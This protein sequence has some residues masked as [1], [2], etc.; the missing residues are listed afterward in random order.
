MDNN[1]QISE[2][3]A[4]GIYAESINDL[5]MRIYQH[6][7]LEDAGFYTSLYLDD[8]TNAE[9]VNF[10]MSTTGF[11]SLQNFE[12]LASHLTSTD[13]DNIVSGTFNL[14]SL[15]KQEI[16]LLTEDINVKST[17]KNNT[18][19]TTL[20]KIQ[21][22]S[23]SII[24]RYGN[25][26]LVLKTPEVEYFSQSKT[27]VSTKDI[28]HL[29]RNLSAHSL[30]YKNASK[31]I[32][33]T[34]DGYLSIPRM[35]LRGY[36]ELFV[37]QNPEF[38]SNQAKEILLRE[39][40]KTNNYLDNM[41]EV[42]KALSLIKN[43]FSSETL[44]NYFRVNNFV[45]YR[46]EYEP[47]FFTKSFDDK[48][49]FLVQILE[50]N[51]NYI[52]SS[53]ETINPRI[54]YNLQQLVSHELSQR[55][56]KSQLN[57]DD[58]EI[59]EEVLRIEKKFDELYRKYEIVQKLKNPDPSVLKNLLKEF[60]HFE[61]R[62]NGLE[63]AIMA[64]EKLESANMVLYNASDLKHLSVEVAVNIIALMGYNSIVSSSFYEDIIAQ[65]NIS[66]LSA[67]QKMFMEK[68]NLD[69]LNYSFG[70]KK[71]NKPYT[72][73]NKLFIIAAI[74]NAI[75][76]GLISYE[77]PPT[78]INETANF[79]DVQ[80]TF[81]LDREDAQVVGTVRDFYKIF[82]SSF[83]TMERP[84]YVITQPTSIM[85]TE[86]PDIPKAPKFTKCPKNKKQPGDD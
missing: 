56:E 54:I 78:K 9:L 20:Y 45:R 80:I 33:Y 65:T 73:E 53:G 49:E 59:F 40:P 46:I 34:S 39:L 82:S 2:S 15:S 19:K 61:A 43:L 63:Q 50:K 62:K 44:K 58:D 83:F 8:F 32:Y 66:K 1:E 75:C 55:Q 41:K 21:D 31:F 60:D 52:S 69:T 35:W 47:A 42:N 23:Y 72:E 81:Y 68:I 51:P 64:R 16:E 7:N 37:N 76:H 27:P 28:F 38:D 67:Q 14:K 29:I 11:L 84:D 57:D 86:I 74:R 26:K 13:I 48:V 25:N 6:I 3:T 79:E 24:S 85:R 70:S 36:S 10:G 12:Q 17:K 30:P 4:R 77:L 71:F 5:L 22:S 18:T